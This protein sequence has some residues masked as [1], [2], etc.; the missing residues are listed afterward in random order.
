MIAPRLSVF[1]LGVTALH[2]QL[3]AQQTLTVPDGFAAVDAPSRLWVAGLHANYH[4]QIV[5]DASHLQSMTG[6]MIDSIRWRREAA[7]EAYAGGAVHLRIELAESANDPLSASPVFAG[8]LGASPT[9][10]FD[11]NVP[12][13]ASGPMGSTGLVWDAAHSLRVDLTTPFPYAGGHLV[14]DVIG[15]AGASSVAWWPA[16]AAWDAATGT[17]QDLGVA[18][19]PFANAA[20]VWAGAEAK[21]LLVGS[22][23]CLWANGTENGLAFLLQSLV[24]PQVPGIPLGNFGVPAVEPSCAVYLNPPALLAIES[25]DDVPAPGTGSGG[26]AD[27]FLPL[28]N[29]P[30]LLGVTLFTQWFD[31]QAMATSNAV[32]GTIGAAAPTLGMTTIQAEAGA[33]QGVLMPDIAHVLQFEYH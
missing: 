7:P 21:T 28:P 4:Q 25:F 31:L 19:G 3:H 13:P 11:G 14:I 17:V 1:L 27:Y 26:S 33:S 6:A 10:V 8:N 20:G 18:C 5:I 15:T 2:T 12:V 9:L 30:W 24:P 29:A 16:D 32:A 23:A 22:S